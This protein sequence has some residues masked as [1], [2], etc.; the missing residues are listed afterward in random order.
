MAPSISFAT[1]RLIGEPLDPSHLGEIIRMHRDP[2]VMA[3]LGG[4]RDEVSSQEY[5]D[6]NLA[7]WRRYGFGLWIVRDRADG[8][9][10]G[11]TVLRHLDVEGVDEVELG[12]GFYP[13]WWG[14]GLATEAARELVRLGFQTL[15]FPSLVAV[16]QTSNVASQ[17][18]LEKAGLSRDRVIEHAGS[19]HLLYRIQAGAIHR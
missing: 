14:R 13:G 15:K 9:I 1:E 4:L 12:Y 17:R 16:T 7:H 19:P 3:T 8:R 2:R 5:L 18:V 11:R 6:F 10:A